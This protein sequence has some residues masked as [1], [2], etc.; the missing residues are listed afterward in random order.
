MLAFAW[1]MEK[2]KKLVS[3]IIEGHGRV[4]V[5]GVQWPFDQC[6]GLENKRSG[7]KSSW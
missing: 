7:Y 2:G 4:C 5:E 3:K 1:K 6:A